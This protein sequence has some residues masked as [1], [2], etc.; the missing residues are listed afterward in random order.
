MHR[1]VL[2]PHLCLLAAAAGEVA[3]LDAVP[4]M[5]QAEAAAG[6]VDFCLWLMP[7]RRSGARAW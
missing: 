2:A 3:C 4:D 7:V 5:V 1:S 6:I